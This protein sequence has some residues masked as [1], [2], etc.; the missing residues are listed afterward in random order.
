LL[1]IFFAVIGLA[2]AAAPNFS[3]VPVGHW[4]KEAVESL[5]ARG[6]I[7][8]FPDG[9]YRGDEY[10]TRYQIAMLV[11]RLLEESPKAAREV[12]AGADPAAL[13]AL[14][15]EVAAL[16]KD[17]E[18]V[19]QELRRAIEP[20]AANDMADD[21]LTKLLNRLDLV[22]QFLRGTREDLDGLKQRI[23]ELEGRQVDLA[24]IAQEN[25]RQLQSLADLLAIFNDD[26]LN[27]KE[28]V[29][30]IEEVL[31]GYPSK[32][33]VQ[34]VLDGLAKDLTTRVDKQINFMAKGIGDLRKEFEERL[35]PLEGAADTLK[36]VKQR[37][38]WKGAYVKAYYQTS[39]GAG[40]FDVDRGDFTAGAAVKGADV[41]PYGQGY[42]E[43]G[44]TL[45]SWGNELQVG[46]RLTATPAFGFG[47]AWVR[48]AG[49]A[50]EFGHDLG[51]DFN[52]YVLDRTDGYPGF[53]VLA[54]VE[55]EGLK[56]KAVGADSGM[57]AGAVE[58]RPFGGFSLGAGY[59]N[60][61]PHRAAYATTNIDVGF[62]RGEGLYLYSFERN[63]GGG[64]VWLEM[65]R[66][67]DP[68]ILLY[69][70][71]LPD[72]SEAELLSQTD[73]DERF[74]MDQT[75]FGAHLKGR[76]GAFLAGGFYDQYTLR[77]VPRVAFAGRLGIDTGLLALLGFYESV[78]E[79]GVVV[80]RSDDGRYGNYRSALGIRAELAP[81]VDGLDVWAE[82]A[83]YPS[84]NAFSFSGAYGGEIGP[85]RLRVLARYWGYEDALKLGGYVESKP[86]E[87]F[88]KPALFAGYVN[89]R[90]GG[91]SETAYQ[92][93]LKV[94][95][96]EGLE[97]K[98][99]YR[100]Y[101]ARGTAAPTVAE[102]ADPLDPDYPGV[103]G[104]GVSDFEFHGF[105]IDASYSS[106][107]LRIDLLRGA[108]DVYQRFALSADWSL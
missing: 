63:L 20:K 93:G 24:R 75:G 43:A 18:E 35:E 30:K 67:K 34:H 50:G 78:T 105:G 70:R 15:A 52:P 45:T 68:T 89:S 100:G 44:T 72:L 84:R 5:A 62:A 82:Y 2:L 32:D 51:L 104:G 83:R 76:L 92:A 27:L 64:F 40:G 108:S 88:L 81:L 107:R 96:L 57:F 10:V 3:D 31:A 91:G 37:G 25:R 19:R 77:G 102:V 7:E 33:E 21:E 8:G 9:T 106:L 59:G 47:R 36:E 46:M 66:A 16:R 58:V 60:E 56:L 41:A 85:L 87:V 14:A 22:V 61:D 38:G 74:E 95:P 53:G 98:A 23:F 69:A 99:G 26:S 42:V 80:D 39:R 48:G 65:G 54:T 90:H 49:L 12:T 79:A 13:R 17:L 101:D 94:Q 97:V 71:M 73:R 86:L 29:V 55:R 28:R 6:I 1:P 103:Y 4:A 11:Y